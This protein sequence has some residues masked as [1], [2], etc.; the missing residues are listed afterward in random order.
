LK[1]N[2]IVA[3]KAVYIPTQAFT[4]NLDG[5]YLDRR[6][7]LVRDETPSAEELYAAALKKA[8]KPDAVADEEEA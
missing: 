3:K 2:A 7:P 4:L 8:A 5:H 6:P 1:L